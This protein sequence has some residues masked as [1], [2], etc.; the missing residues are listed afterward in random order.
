MTAA[1]LGCIEQRVTA[2]DNEDA[3]A[4]VA[5]DA[6]IRDAWVDAARRLDAEPVDGKRMDAGSLAPDSAQPLAPDAMADAHV[7]PQCD[8]RFVHEQPTQGCGL[9]ALELGVE[10]RLGG[11]TLADAVVVFT[12]P[13]QLAD[14]EPGEAVT[15]GFGRAATRLSAHALVPLTVEAAVDC[16]HGVVTATR[17]VRMPA[18][19]ASMRSSS[20]G[21]EHDVLPAGAET[22]C[23]AQLA[24]LTMARLP[25]PAVVSFMG[26]AGQLDQFAV[27]DAAGRAETTHAAIHSTPANVEPLPYE[28][29]AGF[30]GAENPRDRWVTLVAVAAGEE[31]FADFDGDKLYSAESDGFEPWMDL[32]EPFIDADDD[33][34]WEE[35]ELF[36]DS[37][38]DG[39][40]TPPNG[41]WDCAREVWMQTKVL[42]TGDADPARSFLRVTGCAADAGCFSPPQDPTCPPEATFQL[43]P[44]GR[45]TLALRF[46]DR[47]GN[48]LDG[49]GRAR[50]SVEA[51]GLDLAEAPPPA[52]D[53]SDCFTPDGPLAATHAVVVA[54]PPAADDDAVIRARIE[55]PRADGAMAAFALETVVCVR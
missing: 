9:A 3:S 52:L 16:G 7:P 2:D 11:R 55:Y 42:W 35:G 49:F 48:C 12:G 50:R 54:A 21:C 32:G 27:S 20:F 15:D 39:V 22:H 6:R 53:A 18:G 30:E 19:A 37:N 33:G 24:N 17:P 34:N 29:E 5:P 8:L 25:E 13:E 31:Q 4:W 28:I 46:A 36:R 23:A 43:A 51:G 10:V 40:W 38:V 44:G 26:E 41:R 14:F 45:A 47:F 1:C